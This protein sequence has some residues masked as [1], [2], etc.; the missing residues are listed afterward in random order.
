MCGIAGYWHFRSGRPAEQGIVE[1]MTRCLA[2][3]GPD[4]ES[5]LLDGSLA[6]GQ[7]RLRVIDPRGGSQPMPN[8]DGSVQVIFNGEIYNHESLRSDLEARGHRFRTRSDTEVIAHAYEEW[9]EGCVERFNG[10][11]ALA[12][13]D[14]RRRRLTLAR[15]RIGIKPL[16]VWQGAEGLVFGSELKAVVAAPWVSLE[17]DLEALDDFMT[18]E[19]VPGP[20]TIVEGVEKVPPATILTVDPARATP[21]RRTKFWTM[22]ASPPPS[23]RAAA[24]D[25]LRERMRIAV[26]RR[27]MADVPLGAFLSG[28]VD[29][30]IIVGLMSGEEIPRV[31]TFSMGFRDPSYDE[32]PYARLVA[33]HFGTVHREEEVTPDVVGLA[34]ELAQVFDEPFADVS[35]FPTY[36]I[37]RMARKDVTVALSGDGGDE[38]FAGYD[39]YRAHRWAWRLRHLYR[40]RPWG[41][42]DRL[43]DGLPPSSRKK[44][45]VNLAKRFAEGLRRPED[46]EHA[47]WWV[48]WDLAQRRALY[49]GGLRQ[50]LEGRDCFAHYRDRLAEG[51]AA[52]F[53]GLQR[54]L[55]ADITGYLVDDILVKVD[56]MSMAVS[57]EARVP[58]LD[59]EVVEHAMSLPG[60][61]KLSG[62]RSKAILKD[63]FEGLLPP[64]IGKRGKEGFSI[65]MKN[66]LRGPLRQMMEDLLEPG[67]LAQRGWFDGDEV[68]RL[69]GEHL[70]GRQNHA[71]RLWCLMSLELSLRGLERRSERT[72]PG[73]PGRTTPSYDP[74]PGS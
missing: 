31:R 70:R 26:R 18:Y 34:E 39:H 62:G 71:H 1:R 53:S 13:W 24:A 14:A 72:T 32:L 48:F 36:L 9:D 63:A 27:L 50:R 15:D 5:V 6:L 73:A 69:L 33:E 25:E 30:S 20:R 41:L 74:A 66:W 7:R 67:T 42:V 11:F 61:W 45:P 38:L 46:L 21:I 3:R 22:E 29:S 19:Y 17:W 57:L 54:Q 51:S 65:P 52:G 56:R 59:H 2:H 35:S 37:S 12:V 64:A 55:Y 47:R 49:S 58:F 68:Q 60:E 28:G 43:L 10:M 23:T 4:D 44:G 40:T 8:E 16:Y